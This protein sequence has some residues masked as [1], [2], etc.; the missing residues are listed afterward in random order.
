M[1]SVVLQIL[2]LA[3]LTRPSLSVVDWIC[4]QP[5]QDGEKFPD[6]TTAAVLQLLLPLSV[7]L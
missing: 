3:A 1:N 2:G 6:C 5:Q 4:V 7:P